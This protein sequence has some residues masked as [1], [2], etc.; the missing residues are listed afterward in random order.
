ML[1]WLRRFF[2]SGALRLSAAPRDRKFLV[3]GFSWIDVPT[4]PSIV[5]GREEG[6]H[7]RYPIGR[8]IA[9]EGPDVKVHPVAKVR[10]RT[11]GD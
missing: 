9:A 5:R 10:H 1:S 8:D 7:G 4:V 11:A 3:Q 6:E 2:V